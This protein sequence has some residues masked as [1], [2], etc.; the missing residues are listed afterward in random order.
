M[1]D[2][3]LWLPKA[4]SN[5]FPVDLAEVDRASL[6]EDHSMTIRV[7]SSLVVR[8][9]GSGTQPVTWDNSEQNDHQNKN[10]IPYLVAWVDSTYWL[11]HWM[12]T[13]VPSTALLPSSRWM[14]SLNSLAQLGSL[15][16]VS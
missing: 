5:R 1:V 7:D 12:L 6:A 13:D 8:A 3:V 4:G 14:V 15:V 9:F 2:P 16:A 10:N 11:L